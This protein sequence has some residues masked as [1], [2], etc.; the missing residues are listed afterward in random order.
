M[1]STPPIKVIV[2]LPFEAVVIDGRSVGE[3][4]INLRLLWI[5]DRI[6]VGRI[7]AGKGAELA[8]MDRWSFMRTMEEYGVALFAY[9]ADDIRRDVATLELL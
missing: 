3:L 1:D 4:A 5:I 2:E 7:S 9:S 6:R 8:G